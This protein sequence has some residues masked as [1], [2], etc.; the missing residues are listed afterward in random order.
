MKKEFIYITLVFILLSSCTAK[1]TVFQYKDRV[2]RDTV[3]LYKERV[4]T[5]QVIDT[6]TIEQPCDSLG[7]LRNFEK[8]IRT[9]NAKILLKSV[10]GNIQ[11]NV[12]LDSI[13]NQKISKFKSTYEKQVEIKEVEII[14][15]K[16][17]LWM[18]ITLA[19]SILLNF[20]LFR[21]R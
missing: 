5:K 8:E 2:V 19:I 11:V 6:L 15:F 18:I 7:N 21:I 20:L 10:K 12:N 17:P 1:K 4:V 3:N 14:R 16:H 13:V 9:E